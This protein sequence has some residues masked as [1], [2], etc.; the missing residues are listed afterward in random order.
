MTQPPEEQQNQAPAVTAQR[1]AACLIGALVL[2]GLLGRFGVEAPR[3]MKAYGLYAAGFGMAMGWLVCKLAE[4]TQLA[5]LDGPWP[6]SVVVIACTAAFV[7]QVET[8]WMTHRFYA[9]EKAR[10]Y[11]RDPGAMLTGAL[12]KM[13]PQ[14]LRENAAAVRELENELEEIRQERREALA[15]ES[16]FGSFLRHRYGWLAADDPWPFAIW[17]VE[18][19]GG[20]AVAVW[21]VRACGRA[22]A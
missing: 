18:V 2:A 8:A 4:V 21:T 9:R 10:Q 19:L 3:S 13:S 12:A 20:C 11:A 15:R 16:S 5:F 14:S 22:V 1:I 7:G 6:R 17:A